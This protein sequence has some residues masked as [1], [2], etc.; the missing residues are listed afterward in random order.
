M[1]MIC[2]RCKN[3]PVSFNDVNGSKDLCIICT[4]ESFSEFE[5]PLDEIEKML[6]NIEEKSKKFQAM[7]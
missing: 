2:D 3:A 7:L 4:I 1:K 5:D 6:E